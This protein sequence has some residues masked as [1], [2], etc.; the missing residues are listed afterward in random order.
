MYKTP[1]EHKKELFTSLMLLFG[2]FFIMLLLGS[3]V[4]HIFE[5][6]S[7]LE[8][9]YF[10]TI[11]LTS[12]GFSSQVPTHW[13][14]II[15]SVFYLIIG[16]SILIAGLSNIIGFYTAHYQENVSKKFDALKGR[17]IKKKKPTKWFVLN[18]K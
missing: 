9:L 2:A 8:S 4:F 16:V 15:F 12:R 11:S 7:Y 17:L 18:K 13:F 3:L 6:W 14:S 5:D 1:R 10:A